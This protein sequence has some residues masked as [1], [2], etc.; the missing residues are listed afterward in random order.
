MVSVEE[1]RISGWRAVGGRAGLPGLV[2]GKGAGPVDWPR[3]CL[4][5]ETHTASEMCTGQ[6]CMIKW[7]I[8]H[9]NSLLM[10]IIKIWSE[11]PHS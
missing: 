6:R 1:P 9:C 5:M 10:L 7:E 4:S 2:L 8:L 3:S 11:S